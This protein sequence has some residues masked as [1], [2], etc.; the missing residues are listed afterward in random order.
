MAHNDN[1]IPGASGHIGLEALAELR[2]TAEAHLERAQSALFDDN[3]SDEDALSHLD[4]A[5]ACLNT[6]IT[7][8]DAGVESVAA[9]RIAG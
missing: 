1:I 9:V 2:R 6:M 3:I 5:I 8:A 7:D 4:A